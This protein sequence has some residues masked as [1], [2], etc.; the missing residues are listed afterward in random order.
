MHGEKLSLLCL[1][2]FLLTTTGDDNVEDTVA[3]A[4]LRELVGASI[5]LAMGDDRVEEALAHAFLIELVA[6]ILLAIGD[7]RVEDTFAELVGASILLTT[8]AVED[9][10]HA[11]LLNSDFAMICID[12]A[13]AFF[14]AFSIS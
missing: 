13:S 9:A 2:G 11:F 5:L 10:V 4:V 3:H 12:A 1:S 8:D 7:D 6:S 14:L